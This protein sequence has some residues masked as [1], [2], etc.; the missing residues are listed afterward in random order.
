MPWNFLPTDSSLETKGS[1]G[2][3]SNHIW[4]SI[5]ELDVFD[6]RQLAFLIKFKVAPLAIM[7][8]VEKQMK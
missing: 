2:K 7:I 4:K 5:S 8:F 6:D 1:Y 3:W